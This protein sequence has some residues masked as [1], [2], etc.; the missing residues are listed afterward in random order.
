MQDRFEALRQALEDSV[1][2]GPGHA[3]PALRQQVADATSAPEHL[4]ALVDTIERH[5]YQVTDEDIAALRRRHSDDELF[6]IVVAAALGAARRRL[7]A[8]LRAIEEA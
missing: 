6:E 2:R 5:A 8:G 3:P 7:Q 1:L 4:R